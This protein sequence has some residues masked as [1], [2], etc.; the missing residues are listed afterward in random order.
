VLYA[1]YCRNPFDS[2]I[3]LTMVKVGGS[4]IVSGVSGV[5]SVD[6]HRSGQLDAGGYSR[7]STR[8]ITDLAI[9]K[10]NTLPLVAITIVHHR[11]CSAHAILAEQARIQRLP[12]T[13]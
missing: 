9:L 8:G 7:S 2:T 11:Y 4:C 13:K 1:L 5:S 10:Y 12:L 3:V 6:E